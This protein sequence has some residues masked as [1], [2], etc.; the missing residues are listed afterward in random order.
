MASENL[1]VLSDIHLGSDLVD[2]VRPGAPRRSSTSQ[3]R[4]RELVSLLDWY[5][6]KREG[7]RPWRLVIAGD[8]VDFVGMSVSSSMPLETEPN[9]EERVHGLGSSVDHTVRKLELVAEHHAEVFASLASFVAEGNELVIVRGNHDVDFHW[10]PVK[11]AFRRALSAHRVGTGERVEFSDWFYY[12][13]GTVYVEH[14]H[15]YDAY[16]SYDHVLHPVLPSDPR[17]SYRSLSDVLLRY[18]VRPTRGMLESGHDTMSAID[19]L[20]FGARLGFGGMLLLGRRFVVAIAALCAMWRE[21]MSD[22]A[23]WAREEHERKMALLSEARQIS[24]V[25]LKALALLQR[26]PVTRSLF[27]LLAGVMVDRVALA[28][29]SIIALGWLLATRWTLL[30]GL[31]VLGVALALGVL[32]WLWRRA[33]GAI[34]ASQSLREHAP[35]IAALFPAAF[36]VMGHT[37]C[38]EVRRGENGDA[39][40]VNLGAWA[41]EEMEDGRVS[42][43]PASRTHLVLQHVDGQPVAQ[44]FRWDETLGPTR[45]LSPSSVLPQKIA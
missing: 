43:L 45:F 19:Y 42:S 34:D 22:A 25:K 27:R 14:G 23:H 15:Q 29:L 4:D 33:R 12:E 17:R 10:E 8:L 38:P 44:L 20:R 2:H 9:D 16:C 5:R 28:V 1:I 11:E 41:E 18:V 31:E 24:L 26:P 35:H 13:A 6:G 3:R 21:H 37:H 7:G 39:T 36:V 40:Y 32:G 30:L